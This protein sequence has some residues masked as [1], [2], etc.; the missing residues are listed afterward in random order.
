MA[1]PPAPSRARLEAERRAVEA[2]L[3]R[4]ERLPRAVASYFAT[5]NQWQLAAVQSKS[6]RIAVWAGRRSGKT[7]GPGVGR[8]IAAALRHPGAT[9]PVFERTLTCSAA[10]VFW[11]ALRDIDERHKL[12]C[13]FKG[14]LPQ[15][16]TCTFT[17]RATI[18]MMG[19]DTIEAADK[20]RGDA[21]PE[22]ILDEAGG[23]RP[24]VLKYL[25]DEVLDA[26]LLDHRGTL[27][28]LGTP[29]PRFE[30]HPF[31]EACKAEALKAAW[32]R[33]HWTFLDN[34]ALPLGM[35]AATPAE[36]KAARHAEF[37]AMLA[38]KGW[39]TT[40]PIVQREWLGQWVRD[41]NGLVYRLAP[42]N[43]AG[44][45]L[46]DTNAG[47][48][49]FGLGIDLGYEDPTAFVVL[50]WKPGDSRVWVVE[51]YQQGHLIPTAVMAHVERLRARYRF[52]FIVAD[53]GGYGKGPV[54]EMRAQGLPIEAADKRGKEAHIWAVNG[55]LQS[56]Q[57]LIPER[58][59]RELLADL[60][61][62]RKNEDGL[63][64]DADANHLPDA[65]LYGLMRLRGRLRGLG[66]DKAPAE[67]YSL[68]WWRQEEAR[69]EAEAEAAH[70]RATDGTGM[71]VEAMAQL[72]WND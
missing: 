35:E 70:K 18:V 47:G 72:Q 41:E 71:Y 60:Y 42:L 56:G 31:Y 19:A 55:D 10:R 62:L 52:S 9:V 64:N 68:E 66:D 57:V 44:I 1:Q 51:S 14:D 67:K 26:A 3:S 39:D 5:L 24:H 27:T 32:D 4:R 25:I 16:A 23:F 33:F 69:M 38:R 36:R 63:E 21:Y 2:E 28:L 46:P 12:G 29:I 8:A 50:A 40:E 43:H 22:A 58:G 49:R 13:R 11:K 30:G 65:F 45:E 61:G 59:N 34:D 48:W 20:A 54:E 7:Y 37:A 53:T 15:A 17:N 6:R